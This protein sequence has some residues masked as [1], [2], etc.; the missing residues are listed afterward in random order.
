MQEVI[1]DFETKVT[2]LFQS[3]TDENVQK[4]D[5]IEKEVEMGF[6]DHHSFEVKDGV[7]VNE[8]CQRISHCSCDCNDCFLEG[9]I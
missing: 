1:P 4:L 2:N 3:V 5:F 8:S 6:F 7:V 9:G